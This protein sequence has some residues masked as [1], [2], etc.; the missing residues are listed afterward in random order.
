[1]K[2]EIEI[3]D[4]GAD[5]D[6]VALDGVA[7]A[8]I[9]LQGFD[10]VLAAEEFTDIYLTNESGGGEVAF[11]LDG[12]NF[13]NTLR[14]PIPQD[15]DEFEFYIQGATKSTSSRDAVIEIRAGSATGDVITTDDLSVYKVNIEVGGPGGDDDFVGLWKSYYA[16]TGL[17]IGWTVGNVSVDAIEGYWDSPVT[18]ILV[19][20]WEGITSD[21]VVQLAP[22]SAGPPFGDGSW[23]QSLEVNVLPGGTSNFYITGESASSSINDASIF[24]DLS[25]MVERVLPEIVQGITVLDVDFGLPPDVPKGMDVV[26]E[27][28]VQRVGGLGS[29][30]VQLWNSG[31]RI[32][33]LDMNGVEQMNLPLTLPADGTSTV[34]YRINARED[35]TPGVRDAY[36]IATLGAGNMP[37]LALARTA[38]S[39]EFKVADHENSSNF[40]TAPPLSEG[41]DTLYLLEK[42]GEA[43]IDLSVAMQGTTV[44]VLDLVN[45]EDVYWA[46]TKRAGGSGFGAAAGV[47]WSE[48]WGTFTTATP[49][50]FWDHPWS[51]PV[52]REYTVYLGYDDNSNGVFDAD[53]IERRV[54]VTILDIDLDAKTV[55]HNQ[56][57]GEL[58]ESI[59][60]RIGAFVPI[61]NDDDDYDSVHSPDKDQSGPIAYESDLLPI[62]LHGVEPL[63]PGG[64]FTLDVPDNMRVWMNSNRSGE[65]QSG[66][67]EIDADAG[68]VTLYVEGIEEGPGFIKVNWTKGQTTLEACDEIQVTVFGWSG[69]INVPGYSAY[70]YTATLGSGFWATP[71]DGTIKSGAF[72]NDATI[73]WGEGP[74]VGKA[75]YQANLNYVWDLEVNVVQ[76]AIKS[77]LTNSITYNNAP[78]QDSRVIW[79]SSPEGPPTI[80]ANLTV[81][82]IEGPVVGG[83]MRGVE[84]MEMGF[85]QTATMTRKHGDFDGFTV[86]RTRVSS[87]EGKS[88]LDYE[89]DPGTTPPWADAYN[90]GCFFAPGRQ[91]GSMINHPFYIPDTPHLAGTDDMVFNIDGETDDVDRFAIELDV[92]LYFAV[93]TTQAING[94]EIVYTQRARAEWEFD[95]SGIVVSG[96]WTQTGSGT[97]GS[98]AFTEVKDGSVVPTLTGSSMND[99]ISNQ[100]WSWENQ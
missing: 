28:K 45:G 62:V 38:S 96:V 75:V 66:I 32:A 100:T 88:A 42:E 8:K 5:D 52:E 14:V 73:L 69:P 63:I 30:Q 47:E 57:T 67:T 80:I 17:N 16:Q 98:N 99:L 40:V 65:V 15:D 33:L 72:T 2:A 27:A 10:R 86:P 50:V 76:V 90:S 7:P 81:E 97:T 79:S 94:S 91:V 77:G 22:A 26:C 6:F 39:L 58:D 25:P 46:I 35:S 92:Q 54:G 37:N 31:T 34:Q 9:T 20:E 23:K 82:R 24:V 70:R 29:V 56:A 48:T 3:N 74:F 19:T 51:G 1:M 55:N 21:S 85:I 61:N 78:V 41:E 95:G 4:A 59:E 68:D 93:R 64:K 53:E 83:V 43:T 89:T 60:T 13:S 11:S 12:E 44:S 71:S 87:V 18:V 36:L 84:F 49:S